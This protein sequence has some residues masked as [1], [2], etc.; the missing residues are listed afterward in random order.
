MPVPFPPPADDCPAC[1]RLREVERAAEAV[2]DHSKA[3]DC[4]VLRARHPHNRPGAGA[5]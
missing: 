2:G 4:R 1:E 5:S 3:T